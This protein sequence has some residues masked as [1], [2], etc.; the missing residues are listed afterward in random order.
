MIIQAQMDLAIYFSCSLLI[1]DKVSD[2]QAGNTAVVDTNLLF[3]LQRQ[4]DVDGIKYYQI[5]NFSEAVPYL[6]AG[7]S[8]KD[9]R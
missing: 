2:I 6:K 3:T 7:S 9:M 4:L 1:G 8:V 5:A